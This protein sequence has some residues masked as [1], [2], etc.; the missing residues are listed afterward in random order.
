MPKFRFVRSKIGMMTTFSSNVSVKTKA[1]TLA[2]AAPPTT[3][4]Q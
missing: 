2:I 3:S 4:Y 1:N